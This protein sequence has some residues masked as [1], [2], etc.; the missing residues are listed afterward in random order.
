MDGEVAATLRSLAEGRIQRSR[1]DL[2]LE[3][4]DFSRD[5]EAVLRQEGYTPLRVRDLRLRPGIRHPAWFLKDGEAFFG[6]VFLEKFEEGS[7]RP[8][9]GS[10]VRDYRGDWAV[11]L[12]RSSREAVWVKLGEAS[13]FDEDRPSPGR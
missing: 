2:R 11:L 5:F 8:L 13:P 3:G 6:Y 1:H 12:T 7:R 10:V 9:F 4:R